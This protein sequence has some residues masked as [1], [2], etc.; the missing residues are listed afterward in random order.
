MNT[1]KICFPI[2]D[3]EMKAAVENLVG[4]ELELYEERSVTGMEIVFV[5]IIPATAL[6]LQLADFI[7]TH[8]VK[9]PQKPKGDEKEEKKKERKLEISKSRISLYNYP[10]DEAKILLETL[11]GDR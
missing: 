5:A 4:N 1:I 11:L 6:A 10:A 9:D 7:L 2:S 3:S 8:F